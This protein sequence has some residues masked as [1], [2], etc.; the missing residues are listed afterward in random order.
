M[1]SKAQ[2]AFPPLTGKSQVAVRATSDVRVEEWHV[3]LAL[4]TVLQYVKH[5]YV[6]QREFGAKQD[7]ASRIAEAVAYLSLAYGQTKRRVSTHKSLASF[8][9]S[10]VDPKIHPEFRSKQCQARLGILVGRRHKFFGPSI[11]T[12]S[13]SQV[14]SRHLAGIIHTPE[15]VRRYSDCTYF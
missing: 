15:Y 6:G 5:T 4:N 1:R 11:N 2:Q 9:C 8:I 7:L 14:G 12:R 13:T 3:A 10:V